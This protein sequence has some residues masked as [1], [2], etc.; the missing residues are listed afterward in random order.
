MPLEQT[1]LSC[2]TSTL[3]TQR[4]TVRNIVPIPSVSCMRVYQSYTQGVGV[5]IKGSIIVTLA[6]PITGV[7]GF[8]LYILAATIQRPRIACT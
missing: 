1:Q 3:K 7:Q 6:N 4:K 8:Y 5:Q 2:T